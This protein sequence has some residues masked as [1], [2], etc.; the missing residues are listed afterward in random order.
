MTLSRCAR[1]PTTAAATLV[2]CNLLVSCG[3]DPVAAASR[4]LDPEPV[5]RSDGLAVL[6]GVDTAVVGA[7]VRLV[8][9]ETDA[10][11]RPVTPASA[12][13]STRDSTIARFAEARAANGASLPGATVGVARVSDAGA[14]EVCVAAVSVGTT[15]IVATVDGK[16][17]G[18][19]LVVVPATQ[20]VASVTI[21]PAVDTI[22]AGHVARLVLTARGTLGAAAAPREVTWSTDDSTVAALA[23]GAEGASNTS[24]VRLVARH[25]DAHASS[26]AVGATGP[27]VATVEATVDG[28]VARARV[29][30]LPHVAAVR[31][32]ADT[33][34]LH[35]G[36]TTTFV[37]TPLDALGTPIP[38]RPVAWSSSDTTIAVVRANG[39]ISA[40]GRGVATITATSDESFA[41]AHV[42]VRPPVGATPSL[43][44]E[45]EIRTYEGSGQV[46]HPD[47]VRVS[48]PWHGRRFWMA[49]T[50]YPN[51]NERYEN[52]SIY[53]SDD[54]ENWSV[55]LGLTN[56]LARSA[57]GHLSDPDLL[58]DETT[59]QIVLYYRDTVSR[60][61]QHVSD[62]VYR[63]TSD[64]GVQWS[65]PTLAYSDT[66]RFVVSPT[67]VRGPD[68][69][70]RDWAIDAGVDG[71]RA[72]GTSVTL[73]TSSDG[74]AWKPPRAVSIAQPGYQ[75]WHIDVA[76]VPARREYWAL[77]AAYPP[78]WGCG[79]TDLF[80]AT[81]RD[82]ERW[83]TFSSPVL[84][85]GV[86]YAFAAAVYRSTFAVDAAADSVTLWFSGARNDVVATMSV[87][88]WS[89]AIA[90]TS[91]D[92]LLRRVSSPR[93]V[94]EMRRPTPYPARRT[95]AD[96]MP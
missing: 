41:D 49:L 8:L 20:P 22:V 66:G 32:P 93:T 75:I 50:P 24:R 82:G 53:A 17:S 58:Y 39:T 31:V 80:L 95:R 61:G 51:G 84:A 1:R 40:R 73:R 62:D 54:G 67:V 42:A 30:V 25:A 63:T 5:P 89:S 3:G 47:V 11:G 87:T 83:T 45:L 33:A 37:A 29:V 6:P 78:A 36:D 10:G 15:M 35:V 2:A 70:W 79:Y 21:S 34:R 65:A 71:C 72:M 44:T 81:S 90:R 13:W 85:R 28:H 18:T 77:Y 55:P 46:V 26:M 16:A 4:R 27:G 68:G 86:V 69:T 7:R 12:V 94:A 43:A 38:G 76:W 52:P 91:V 9:A 88:R 23:P 48:R 56:P 19:R 64:D 59:G 74:R 60:L 57:S 96:G 92:D 14:V